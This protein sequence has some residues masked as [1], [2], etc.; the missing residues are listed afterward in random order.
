MDAPEIELKFEVS[1]KD[2]PKLGK[3]P[4]LGTPARSTSL[5]S[6]YFDTADRDLRN[7]CFGL[8][9]RGDD[10]GL[11]QTL[12]W[13]KQGAPF[14]RHEWETD[15][16]S[17]RPDLTALA[18]TPASDVIGGNDGLLE[19]VF[20]T[21]VERIRRLWTKDGDVVEVSLDR[22]E[23]SSGVRTEPIQELELEL[24]DGDPQALFDLADMLSKRAKL[25]LLFQSKAERGYDLADGSHWQPQHAMPVAIAPE[26]PAGEAFRDL[27]HNCLAQV[28]NNARLLRRYRSLEALH[29]LRVGLRR[30]RAALT[31]FRSFAQDD[32]YESIKE[33]TKWL[34]NE[35][36]AARDLDVFIRESFRRVTPQVAERDAFAELGEHLLNSQSKAYDRAVA[37]VASQRFAKLMLT[38]LRWT[39]IGSWAKSDDPVI[40][41]LRER[42]I[43][44]FAKKQLGRMDRKL[45]R[46]GRDLAQLDTQARHRLRI[47]AKKLRYASEFFSGTFGRKERQKRFLKALAKLQDRLG[48]LHDAAVSPRLMLCL[49]R[50]KSAKAGFAAG[51]IVANRRS[52]A[53]MDERAAL[54]R[55]EA[56]DG[57]KP[58]W[59]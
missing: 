26:T 25:R 45:R 38:T 4:A 8:R 53:K 35:L 22:G 30:F 24:K 44:Q 52:S 42:R 58:F 23:I 39:A 10:D 37:A 33:E 1:D 54:K 7:A 47:K 21:T 51:L 17:E 9:V 48:R 59:N 49:V 11:V 34:A 16:Q 32:E 19:P 56:F 28:A 12:K 40:N 55:F 31:T 36:D 18:Q 13:E 20:T 43:D 3:H 41:S 5:R 15:V 2:L 46:R 27:A 14:I 50:G 57:T 6:I 29:Q